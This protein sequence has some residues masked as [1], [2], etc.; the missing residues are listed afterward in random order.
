V[1]AVR[2]SLGNAPAIGTGWPRNACEA[3]L[4]VA[5]ASLAAASSHPTTAMGVRGTLRPADL[6]AS[7]IRRTHW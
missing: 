4:T 6:A 2:S 3:V 5:A 7:A 1:T